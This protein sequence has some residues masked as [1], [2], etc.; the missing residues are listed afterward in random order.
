[1]F[2]GIVECIGIVK[3]IPTQNELK[4]LQIFAPSIMQDVN[5]NDSVAVNG[6]CLTVIARDSENFSVQPVPETLRKTNL[7]SLPV[8]AAVNLERSLL[9]TSR[10]GGHF[11]QGHI[12][13][14][15]KIVSIVREGAALLVKFSLPKSLRKYLVDKGFIAID[16]MSLTIIE[17]HEDWFTVTLIPHTQQI[18]IAGNYQEGTVVNIEVDILAKYSERVKI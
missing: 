9:P 6:V 15:A 3:D 5:V 1:M 7:G 11:V 12:D 14:T 17:A 18:T 4:R 13:D 10:L 16:G 2:T 8:N